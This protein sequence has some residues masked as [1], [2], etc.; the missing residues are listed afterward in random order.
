M[1]NR[2]KIFI[3][4]SLLSLSF[5]SMAQKEAY[6]MNV[7]GVKVIVH[8]ANNQLIT[9]ITVIKGG[10][11]NYPAEKQ[12]I[13]SLA[14]KALTECGTVND[15]KNSFKNKLDKVSGQISGNSSM[16]YASLRMNCVSTDFNVVWPLYSDALTSP[17]FDENEFARIRKDAVNII[18]DSES[19]PD[20]AINKYAKKVAFRGKNYAKDPDGTEGVVSKLTVAEVKNYYKSIL[21]RGKMLIVVV[22]DMDRASLETKLSEMLKKIPAGTPYTLK[23]ESY[24]PAKGSFSS[25]K[26]DLATNYIQ[27]VTG[28]P[29]PGTPEYNAYQLAMNIFSN[30]Y[31]LEVRSKNGLSYAPYAYFS[32]GATSTSNIVVS[33]TEPDKYINVLNG[34]ITKVKKDGFTPEEVKN[35]KAGY[36][37]SVY[38]RQETNDAQAMSLVNNEVLHGNWKRS[39]T[40]KEDIN[41]VTPEQV[42][43]VF[44]KYMNNINW[45][46]MGNPAKVNPALFV[47]TAKTLPASTVKPAKKN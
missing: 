40:I 26:K 47:P 35:E 11:Q 36:V 31:F 10:V 45:V 34:L 24:T 37:T 19:D 32:G 33:T 8:P 9:I 30:K 15:D 29:L 2:F 13:E 3:I 44:N 20:N 4:I 14:I 42:N 23:K 1:K 25:T 39:L 16:D 27:G 43:A 6:E 18:R 21:T 12:G 28:A 22:A 5:T 41:K 38:Y 46:Y 17:K 7:E